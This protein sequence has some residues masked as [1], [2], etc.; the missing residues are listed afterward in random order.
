[1]M[2]DGEKRAREPERSEQESRREASKRAGEKERRKRD[3]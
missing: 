2:W 1:M 3:V